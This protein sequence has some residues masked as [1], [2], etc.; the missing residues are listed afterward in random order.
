MNIRKSEEADF[1]AMLAIV[2][3]AA[4]AYRGVIPADRWHE[5][6]VPAEE[7]AQ[8]IAEGVV[9]WVAEEEGR[10]AGVM[11]IQDRGDVALRWQPPFGDP[12]RSQGPPCR[13]S[14]PQFRRVS[15][16]TFHVWRQQP[17]PEHMRSVR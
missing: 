16:F 9:F 17:D 10:L 8:Q 4:R 7:L 12:T 11:G 15:G 6:Y 2:N 1:T 3:E 14:S 5:P 13:R